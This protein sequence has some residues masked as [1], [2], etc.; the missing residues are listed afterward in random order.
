MTAPLPAHSRIRHHPKIEPVHLVLG[1][2]DGTRHGRPRTAAHLKPGEHTLAHEHPRRQGPAPLRPATHLGPSIRA[3]ADQLHWRPPRQNSSPERQRFTPAQAL[4][5]GPRTAAETCSATGLLWTGARLEGG[6]GH[7]HDGPHHPSLQWPQ[8]MQPPQLEE[9][10][11]G[12]K[13]LHKR[14]LSNRGWSKRPH[15]GKRPHPE[16]QVILHLECRS[17]DWWLPGQ[18]GAT[19]PCSCQAGDNSQGLSKQFC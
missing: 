10:S 6:A 3:S 7:G 12:R 2:V 18:E 16:P 11:R 19:A 4:R 17:P 1:Q 9:L 5:T 8:M 15:P 13:K 14:I